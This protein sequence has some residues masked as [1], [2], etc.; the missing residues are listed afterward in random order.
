VSADFSSVGVA[1]GHATDAEGVTGLTVVRAIDGPLRGAVAVLG[2]ASGSREF[3]A[4]SPDSLADRVDA[5][6]LTG[7]SAYGLDAASG[8][9]QWMEER[10]RGFPISGGVVPIVPAAVIFDLAASGRFHA[11]PTPAMA[12]Q[13]TDAARTEGIAEGSVGVGAG[14]TVGK[15]AG[16]G[17]AM[18]GGVGCAVRTSAAVSVAALAVVNAFGDIRDAQGR[19]IA[20]AR[21][22]GGGFLDGAR[23]LADD[24]ARLASL[25]AESRMSNTTL[26]VVATT[27]SLDRV[28]LAALARAAGAA[29]YRRIT[30]VATPF[31]GDVVFALCPH[32]GVTAASPHVE[33]LAVDALEDAIERSVRAA[34]GR[35]GVPGL[36][37]RA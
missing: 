15:A 25:A 4:L 3:T 2:R 30:P 16:L 35:T 5:I 19:I 9:M 28:Q 18:K 31:D 26:A 21:A 12:Y 23:M 20:G 32:H 8:V 34:V 22:Q 10:G 6:M 33:A 11:R 14:A 24:P 27:A 13:A 7:G 36:A 1:V 37:D 29:L 17:R